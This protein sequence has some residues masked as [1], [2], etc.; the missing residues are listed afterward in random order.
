M[1][2]NKT[3]LDE[4]SE[5]VIKN[6]EY[7]SSDKQFGYFIN[8]EKLEEKIAELRATTERE[9]LINGYV[10][11]IKSDLEGYTLEDEKEMYEYAEQ[12]YNGRYGTDE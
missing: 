11:G 10:E 9:K 1:K 6:Y 7:A 5:W 2:N 4:L 3:A 8:A 12:W